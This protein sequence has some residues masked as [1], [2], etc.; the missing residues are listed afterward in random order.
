MDVLV[1]VARDLIVGST[2]GRFSG[3]A[4][5]IITPNRVAVGEGV[6]DPGI[7]ADAVE[8]SLLD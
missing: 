1:S 8:S 4:V 7:N 2:P 5:G 6:G 3:V